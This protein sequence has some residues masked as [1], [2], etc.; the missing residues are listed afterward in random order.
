MND[1][2]KKSIQKI[3]SLF[4]SI[5]RFA[6]T[7]FRRI[8]M[9]PSHSS[10]KQTS[11]LG[12]AP[13]YALRQ[14]RS[15]PLD[16][17]TTGNKKANKPFFKDWRL[18]AGLSTLA[19]AATLLII[20]L[21][22]GSAE[23]AFENKM[24]FGED[25]PA[26]I[27]ELTSHKADTDTTL[28]DA[29]YQ[30]VPMST[31]QPDDVFLL[32]PGVND[33]LIIKIQERLMVLGY[34]P[35][36]E[37]TDYY[38]SV[39][40]YALQLF[41]RSHGLKIDGL[42]GAETHTFLYADDAKPYTVR[43]GD[44]GTDVKSLQDRLKELK[45]LSVRSSGFFGEETQK[46]VKSF[47]SRNGLSADGVVGEQTWDKLYSDN[48]RPAGTSSSSGSSSGSSSSKASHTGPL[49]TSDPDA[50]MADKLIEFAE[51]LL[52]KKY[53]RGGK[54]PE[55]FD[56]SGFVYYCLRQIGHNI[57]YMTSSD[58]AK[59]SLPRVVKMRDMKRGDII[60]FRKHVGIYMG[61]GKMIDASAASGK[62]VIRSDIF[63]SDYWTRN[64]ICA[65]RVF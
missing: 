37:P 25:M 19:A 5:S 10:R 12:S 46:A 45:Y 59:S 47:Q 1:F 9:Q 50:A 32:K 6:V 13:K 65:R 23:H 41:Q 39:T 60:C 24:A 11:A 29:S 17:F 61:N 58:W 49:A 57:R 4:D 2:T 20:L 18:Y 26:E 63:N 38:G 3:K 21:P 16:S 52:G 36:D 33:P 40:E 28:T 44:K 31:T 53:V 8:F 48:A 27:S 64:F 22:S 56:C 30:Q 51:T 55:V 34:M 7:L 54:G 35:E 42:L 62:V 43:H 15:K 14:T